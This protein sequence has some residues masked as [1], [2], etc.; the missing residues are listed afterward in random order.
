M[1]TLSNLPTY[2][3]TA[4][5]ENFSLDSWVGRF[6]P[7]LENEGIAMQYFTSLYWGMTTISTTGYGRNKTIRMTI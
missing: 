7:G 3:F 2:T 5:V 6:D 1:T 4:K